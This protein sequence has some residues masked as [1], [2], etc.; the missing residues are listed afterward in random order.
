MA[1]LQSVPCDE[2]M[3]NVLVV[4]HQI[5][6]HFELIKHFPNHALQ[7]PVCQRGTHKQTWL[8]R[9]LTGNVL[10]VNRSQGK[11]QPR[12]PEGCNKGCFQPHLASIR[13]G[14]FFP[15]LSLSNCFVLCQLFTTYSTRHCTGVLTSQKGP[16]RSSSTMVAQFS[17]RND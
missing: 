1:R 8:T 12:P 13:T 2:E 9:Y 10:G 6:M 3:S 14:S 11:Q 4:K 16:V 17:A 7:R 5:S 15:R